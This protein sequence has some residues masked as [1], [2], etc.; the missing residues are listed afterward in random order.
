[1]AGPRKLWRTT[2]VVWSAY[3]P[4]TLEIANLIHDAVDGQA[5][6]TKQDSELVSN[7]YMQEDGPP[8]D[9]FETREG[10]FGFQD[11]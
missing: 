1:M 6:I 8:E 9:F 10:G 4:Q 11:A 2:I 5:I 7:P 3:D